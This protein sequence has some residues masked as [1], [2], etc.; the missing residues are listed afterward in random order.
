V[1]GIGFGLYL[2]ARIVERA[3]KARP[4]AVWPKPLTNAAVFLTAVAVIVTLPAVATHTTA[5]AAALAFAGALYLA[6]AYRGRYHRLG[7]LGMAMLQLA[8]A[9]AL[10]VRDVTQPQWCC[11]SL[12]AWS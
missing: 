10:I 1:G 11:C 7:Y 6:I 4:L 3:Q 12:R 8:W 2:L 9:L 5:V